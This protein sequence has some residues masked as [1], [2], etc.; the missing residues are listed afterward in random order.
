MPS[1]SV[2]IPA[3]NAEQYIV[4]T[5]ESLQNQTFSDFEI[6]VSDDASTDRT[7]PIVREIGDPR[8]TVISAENGGV[9]AARNRGIAVARGEFIAFLDADDL[10]DPDKL[11]LQVEALRENPKAGLSYGWFYQWNYAVH[12]AA[13]TK[14]L[15]CPSATGPE[16]YREIVEENVVGSG[17]NIFVRRAA[18]DSVG[19]FDETLTHGEDWEFCF[20]VALAWEVALIP[21]PLVYYRQHST[22]NCSSL[23]L[24]KA[25]TLRTMDKIFNSAPA[26]LRYLKTKTHSNLY[27]YLANLYL[28]RTDT[29]EGIR[30]ARK[31]WMKSIWT[32]PSNLLR[33]RSVTLSLK[34][35]LFSVF[36]SRFFNIFLQKFRTVE[37][38]RPTVS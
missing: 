32:W 6:I 30:H 34:I 24:V 36:P 18:L 10:W 27:L 35:L 5:I 33:K 28:A 14:L 16:A 31:N 9:S 26:E 8:L 21:Q 20:R 22:S 38:D 15:M 23:D 1:V 7:V 11:R 17:S 13:E 2:V 3:Y 12:K 29:N 37:S 4:E 25:S 19:G